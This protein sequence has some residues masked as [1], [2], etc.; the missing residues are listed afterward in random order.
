MGTIGLEDIRERL[1]YKDVDVGTS[2]TDVFSENVPEQVKRHIVKIILIGPGSAVTVDIEKKKEDG[3]YEMIFNG[4]NVGA[5]DNEWLP[6]GNINLEHPLVV[7]EGGTNLTLTGSAALAATII[8]WDD[9]LS[10]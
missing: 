4:Y 8:Y 3:T 10:A 1:K 2:R 9:E 5:S 6:P 7:L